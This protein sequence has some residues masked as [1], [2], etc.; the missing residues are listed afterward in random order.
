M[1]KNFGICGRHKLD[2]SLCIRILESV[3]D[4]NK[5]DFSLCIRILKR[6]HNNNSITPGPSLTKH[7][8]HSTLHRNHLQQ[9]SFG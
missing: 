4:T 7:H 8:E 5:L 6:G 1:Y 2:V 3:E 9:V